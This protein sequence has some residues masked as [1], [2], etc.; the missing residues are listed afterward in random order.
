MLARLGGGPAGKGA[1]SVALAVAADLAVG[2]GT[3]IE[4]LF[5]DDP[6]VPLSEALK[7]FDEAP[8]GK[9]ERSTPVVS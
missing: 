8:L 6:K 2:F 7:S 5:S 3:S 1:S 9:R 4:A